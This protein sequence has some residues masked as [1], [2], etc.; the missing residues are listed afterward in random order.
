MGN[1]NNTALIVLGCRDRERLRKRIERLPSLLEKVDILIYSG[2]EGEVDFMNKI[3]PV[4]TAIVENKSTTTLENLLFS[5]EII[6]KM[7]WIKR[8]WIL[9]DRAHR[10]RVKF[11]ANRVFT[12]YRYEIIWVWRRFSINEWIYEAV[13]F[14]R[15]IMDI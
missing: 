3:Y 15:H 5:K 9:T 7:P 1:K 8:I 11:L 4:S 6:R 2:A 12:E 14:V 10:A 13:R